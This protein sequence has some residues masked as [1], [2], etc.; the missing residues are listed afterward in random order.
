MISGGY[1][2]VITSVANLS[3]LKKILDVPTDEEISDRVP[4]TTIIVLDQQENILS[5]EETSIMYTTLALEARRRCQFHVFV[6][7][8][9][10]V[11]AK[12]VLLLNGGDKINLLCPSTDFRLSIAA[13]DSFINTRLGNLNTSQ[14]QKLCDLAILSG[15]V[16]ILVDA[17]N[18]L[19]G[20]NALSEEKMR[21][22]EARAIYSEKKWREFAKIDTGP[23]STCKV[24]GL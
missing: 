6:C 17:A 15:V 18:E 7:V 2:K 10:P 11:V 14:R 19:D 12:S 23:Y 20:G 22:L 1:A 5:K 3:E 21:L 8:S 9:K 24:D 13:V 16:S 4:K